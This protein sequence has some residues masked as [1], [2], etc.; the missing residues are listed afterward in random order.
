MVDFS[1][2]NWARECLLPR[3]R[4]LTGGGVWEGGRGLKVIALSLRGQVLRS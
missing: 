4:P 2:I 1:P 3:M